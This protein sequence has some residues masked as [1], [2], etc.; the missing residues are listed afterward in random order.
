MRD[1][2][3][4]VEKDR[5]QA[6]A[7]LDFPVER[8]ELVTADDSHDRVGRMLVKRTDALDRA[9]EGLG[10]VKSTRP[11]LPFPMIMDWMTRELDAANLAYKLKE[12][13]V[14]KKGE[15]YQEYIFD[16]NLDTPDGEG[17][18]PM[19]IVKGS[20]VDTPM[21]AFFGTYRFTC[22]NGVIVGETI[23]KIT[24]KPNVMDLIQTSITDD[25]AMK[26]D[27]FAK[28]QDLYHNLQAEDFQPYLFTLFSDM[29]VGAKMKK[30]ILNMLIADG[31]VRVTQEK[32]RSADLERPEELM[33]I[34]NS[35][36]AWEFYNIAT[37]VATRHSRSVQT[38][39]RNYSRISKD[40]RI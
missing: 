1:Y 33:D 11:H 16:K 31:N 17:I 22:A 3:Q 18:A 37:Q 39:M 5:V 26:I 19:M 27:Q 24:V 30:E 36:T 20:Y 32:I 14:T 15:M 10:V 34:V 29:Y 25:L 6:R 2:S 40:F 35:I 7:E 38:R 4:I 23:S 8:I 21:E 9:S 12:S 28:V 13:M